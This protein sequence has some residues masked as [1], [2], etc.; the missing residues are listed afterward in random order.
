LFAV[1]LVITL[2]LALVFSIAYISNLL[3][4]T[5][6]FSVFVA[7]ACFVLSFDLIN[8]MLVVRTF[9]SV[10]TGTVLKSSFANVREHASKS[11][12]L[13][14]TSCFIILSKTAFVFVLSC[15]MFKYY[16][17]RILCFLQTALRLS[18]TFTKTALSVRLSSFMFLSITVASF[19]S[20]VCIVFKT[21]S[22]CSIN[23]RI[24]V[25]L[26]HF[27]FLAWVCFI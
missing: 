21:A 2:T 6:S 8:L 13:I 19:Y 22:L 26:L 4:F 25:R 20:L 1:A 15:I 12:S 11:C 18:S 7:Y 14:V 16:F 27:W 24:F 5:S 17:L 9:A 23:F 10:Y 3:T